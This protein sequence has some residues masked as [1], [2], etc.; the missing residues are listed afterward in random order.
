MHRARCRNSFSQSLSRMSAALGMST[1]TPRNSSP[2]N[3]SSLLR[4][5]AGSGVPS[6]F[7]SFHSTSP[8]PGASL[9]SPHASPTSTAMSSSH[10]GNVRVRSSPG[11]V[12]DGSASPPP[13]TPRP[14]TP[15][16][17]DFKDWEDGT[18][19]VRQPIGNIRLLQPEGPAARTRTNSG[20]AHAFDGPL[21][22]GRI[23]VYLRGLQG[24][25]SEATEQLFQAHRRRS[26][27]VVQGSFKQRVPVGEC[28]PWQLVML[29]NTA[30]IHVALCPPPLVCM[31]PTPSPTM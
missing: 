9:Q 6:A 10:A 27:I 26:W 18:L 4:P 24:K 13:H 5:S 23:A 25:H 7:G 12:R 1:A 21:F 29:C 16:D 30:T 15:L 14:F 8:I 22:S 20:E 17:A 3:G 19:L 31:E 2:R 28:A 11:H